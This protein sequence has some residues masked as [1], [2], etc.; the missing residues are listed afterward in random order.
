MARKRYSA[1]IEVHDRHVVDGRRHLRGDEPLPDQ[2][3]EP[4]LVGLE[5]RLHLL[6][7]AADVGGPDGLVRALHR[8]VLPAL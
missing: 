6:R 2:L 7:A 1:E 4:V 8:G 5:M 3:V